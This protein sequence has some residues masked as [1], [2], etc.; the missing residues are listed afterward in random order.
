MR[1]I[2]VSVDKWRDGTKFLQ[3]F[4]TG[5]SLTVSEQR[6]M[7]AV[8]RG[9]YAQGMNEAE[10][11]KYLRDGMCWYLPA[12]T[13]ESVKVVYGSTPRHSSDDS[14]LVDALQ[15]LS[16]QYMRGKLSESGYVEGLT[17]AIGGAITRDQLCALAEVLQG[18]HD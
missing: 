15:A 9:P 8:L 18:V 13:T 10:A 3:G 12:G 1:L 4:G 14:A 6:K 2:K 17:T 11:Q 7:K 16:E 5:P